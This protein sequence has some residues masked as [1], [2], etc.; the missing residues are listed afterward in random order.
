MDPEFRK[1]Q[2]KCHFVLRGRHLKNPS[3]YIMSFGKK[4]IYEKTQNKI[5]IVG[6]YF[7]LTIEKVLQSILFHIF[8]LL[9]EH[10]RASIPPIFLKWLTTNYSPDLYQ[11]SLEVS[12]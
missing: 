10:L 4:I 1:Y 2:R 5:W 7:L 8:F 6:K 3:S 9:F 12:L 11:L